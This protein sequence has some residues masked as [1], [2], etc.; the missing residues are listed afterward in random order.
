[1]VKYEIINPS[2]K[3]FISSENKQIAKF[4]CMLLGEGKY[5]LENAE[6]GEEAFPIYLFGMSEQTIIEEL[7]ESIESFFAHHKKEIADCLKTFEYASE[8]TSLNNIGKRAEL[9][10]K[11]IIEK[12]E[13][14]Q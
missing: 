4:C 2:D 1:M 9:Y 10:Y 5:G 8:R 12:E 7:G 14:N 3:C 6:T 11:K 13:S